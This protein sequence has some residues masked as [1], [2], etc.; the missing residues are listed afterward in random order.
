MPDPSAY[1]VGDASPQRQDYARFETKAGD[2]TGAGYERW[3]SWEW[4]PETSRQSKEDVY[5]PH[6]RLLAVV[7]CYPADMAVGEILEHMHG[8]DVHHSAPEV[9]RDAGIKWDNRPDAIEVIDHG[10]HSAVTQ[11]EMRAWAADAKRT[12]ETETNAKRNGDG[13]TRCGADASTL[14]EIAG[15]DGEYCLDC[16]QT[17]ADGREIRV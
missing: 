12:I 1:V 4:R 10:R 16:A 11:A 3:R 17:V 15:E 9:D 7:A 14:A 2:G 5:V 6:H 8:M 13:C